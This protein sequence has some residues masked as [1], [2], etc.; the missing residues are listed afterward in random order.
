MLILGILEAFKL[1]SCLVSPPGGIRS[2]KVKI[3]FFH[4]L[5][6]IFW[7]LYAL[8]PT[9]LS[10]FLIRVHGCQSSNDQCRESIHVLVIMLALTSL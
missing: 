5:P 2:E 9:P 10:V 3:I 4:P 7:I 8:P 6:K 1:K